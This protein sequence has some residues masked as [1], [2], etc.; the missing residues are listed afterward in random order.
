[1]SL[2]SSLARTKTWCFLSV[3][4]C[5]CVCHT[6]SCSERNISL[7]FA[8][9]WLMLYLA[10]RFRPSNDLRQL[11]CIIY[12]LLF[13]CTCSLSIG[14]HS[15]HISRVYSLLR[16]QPIV[17]LCSCSVSFVILYS[18]GPLCCCPFAHQWW[19][20]LLHTC[21]GRTML[22]PQFILIFQPWAIS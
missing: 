18:R 21:F 19:L 12:R 4:W 8:M 6:T 9:I 5:W 3:S 14:N 17:G 15:F 22:L 16:F 20:F 2:T 7:E 13:H 1:M 11:T 10:Y